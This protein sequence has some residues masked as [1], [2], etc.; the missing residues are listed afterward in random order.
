SHGDPGVSRRVGLTS[1]LPYLRAYRL[2]LVLVAV[3]SLVRRRRHAG[4]AAADPYRPRRRRA[5]H[6]LAVRGAARRGARRR[7]RTGRPARLPAVPYR[8]GDRAHVA[9]AVGGAPAAVAD[10]RVRPA[11]H[12]GPAVPG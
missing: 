4:A 10:H 11:P 5:R 3:L 7:G 9:P 2:S 12:R 6:R 1:L 8:R